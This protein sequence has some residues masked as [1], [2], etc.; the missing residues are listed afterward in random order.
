MSPEEKINLQSK[1]INDAQI[2]SLA[3]ANGIDP[4]YLRAFTEVE[5]SGI[6]FSDVTGK[7]LIQFEP[8]YMKR[9]LASEGIPDAGSWLNNGIGNQPVEYAAFQSAS[10]QSEE[11]A[12][13]SCSIGMMQVMA[14]NY[15]MVGF[16]TVQAMWSYADLSEK[17]QVE[18]GVRFIMANKVLYNAVKN[19]VSSVVAYYYNG[20][21]YLELAKKYNTIPYDQRLDNAYAKFVTAAELHKT[22]TTVNIRT[23]P[24]VSFPP[25]AEPLRVNTMLTILASKDG[26][27]WVKVVST[28]LTGY[29]S[30]Q[31]VI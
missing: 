7:M 19:K 29:I 14:A 31:Y 27:T 20:S 9:F 3:V 5:G 25:A 15:Q 16:P 13:K 23:G 12:M 22:S 18:I 17:N 26:W 21:G 24:G 11:A 1:K 8:S 30:S 2:V 10:A 4:N 28:N 6:G